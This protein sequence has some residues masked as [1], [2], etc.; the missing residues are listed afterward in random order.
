[1]I[2]LALIGCGEVAESG[3]LP[4]IL[5]HDRFRLAAVCDVDAARAKLFAGLAGGVPAYTDW[6]ELLAHEQE[7]DGVVLALPPEVSPDVAIEALRRGLAVLDEKPLAATVADGRRLQ[8]AVEE[9]RGIYQIGFVLR[10]GDWV[11]HVRELTPRLGSPLQI[12]VEVYDE[13]LNPA[14]PLHL[15]RILSFIK[16]S[17]AMT[18]EGSHVIDYVSLW[19]PSPWT[20]VSSIAQQTNSAFSGPNVWNAKVELADRSTLDVKVAWLLPEI[21]ESTVTLIGPEGRVEFNCI[22]GKGLVETAGV[23]QPF[24]APPLAPHWGRQYHAFAEAIERG[25]ADYA[26]VYDGL[27]ALETTAACELSARSGAS[28]TP[29]ELAVSLGLPREDRAARVASNGSPLP[30][31]ASKPVNW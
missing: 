23:E 31:P 5:H 28:V 21:P 7:L 12:S 18:H 11:D 13:R 24:E 1:M 17:S 4:T 20:R 19:N 2:S 29:D 27:R 16:N 26:T 9:T 8:L 22:T 10:Y 30:A 6:R 14:D 3:H 15:A 25:R